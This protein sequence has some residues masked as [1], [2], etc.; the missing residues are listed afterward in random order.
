MK[1]IIVVGLI[2][3]LQMMLTVNLAAQVAD[4]PKASKVDELSAHANCGDV[5][6]RLDN[7]SVS[8]QSDPGATGYV[9]LYGEEGKTVR[10]FVRE[11]LVKN[12]LEIR[13]L[14]FS[15]LNFLQGEMR[16][17]A[18]TEFWVVPAGANPPQIGLEQW[19]YDLLR[20]TSMLRWLQPHSLC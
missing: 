8:L 18:T 15:R 1:T 20:R 6:A 11:L 3:V 10:N 17:N 13:G 5:P 9:V 7:F 19:S 12:H 14:D 4:E 16:T 2:L